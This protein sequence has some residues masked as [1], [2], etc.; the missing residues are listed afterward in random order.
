MD[1][2]S[3]ASN[4][5]ISNSLSQI[6]PEGLLDILSAENGVYALLIYIIYRLTKFAYD[7]VNQR[8]EDYKE[9]V[10]KLEGLLDEAREERIKAQQSEIDTLKD[11]F[12]MQNKILNLNESR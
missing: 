4:L 2:I 11:F 8:I 3:G 9:K 12:R 7:S 6:S 1:F 5:D 10:S